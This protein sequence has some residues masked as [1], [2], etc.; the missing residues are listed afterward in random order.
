MYVVLLVT[1]RSAV[2][3][4]KAVIMNTLS[5]LGAY[6]AL[7]LIFQD[8]R[9]TSLLNYT[10]TGWV[11]AIVPVLMFCV[12][13]GL[14]MDYEVFLL[15]RVREEYLQT[16]DNN[17]AVAAGLEK[18]GRIV[19]SAAFILII[20]ALSFSLG[21]LLTIKQMGVGLAIAIALD[22]SI[23]RALLVPATMALL[24]HWNWW[25]PWIK[26]AKNYPEKP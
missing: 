25:L 5:I 12:L 7:V 21:G 16:G 17:G 8:G 23:V 11:D 3:P 2:L 9:L 13:F 22:A 15:S 1:F 19:T 20:V 10:S 4:L 6:G 18:T 26:R 24:G 14:S